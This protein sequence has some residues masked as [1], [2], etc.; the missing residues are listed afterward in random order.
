MF[1]INM[2]I[3][4]NRI[5]KKEEIRKNLKD[6]SKGKNLETYINIAFTLQKFRLATRFYNQ[7]YKERINNDNKL[8]KYLAIR[9]NI[10]N[11]LIKIHNDKSYKLEILHTLSFINT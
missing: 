9:F 4:K 8:L 5:L 3:N 2:N 10:L 1:N 11:L 7:N 6:K